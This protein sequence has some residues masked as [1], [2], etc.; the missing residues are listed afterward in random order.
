MLGLV[1]RLLLFKYGTYQLDLNTFISWSYTLVDHGFSGFYSSAWSDYLPGYL[2]I[3]KVLGHINLS[4][5]FD[6]TLLFKLPAI[7]SDLLTGYLIFLIVNKK[8]RVKWGLAASA[9]YVFNPA[10]ILNSTLWGQVDSITALSI[11]LSLYFL[12]KYP[13]LS[14]FFLAFGT[15]FKPQAAF[16]AP[17]IFT[18]MFKDKWKSSKIL[19]YAVFGLIVFTLGFAPFKGDSALLPFILERLQISFNQYPYGSVNAFNF[20]GLWGF[21]K[22]DNVGILGSRVIGLIISLILAIV[23]LFNFYIKK[24]K[25]LSIYKAASGILLTTFL[26]LTKIHERHLLPVFAPL[27]TSSVTSITGIAIYLGYSV[28]YALNLMY[29]YSY[30]S[31]DHAPTISEFSIKLLILFNLFLFACFL[32][33]TTGKL[34]RLEAYLSG[35]LSS[36]EIDITKAAKKKFDK[37]KLRK[38]FWVLLGFTFVARTLFLWNPSEEYFDE[39]YHAFTARRMY[40]GDP[41]AWQWWNTPP[42]GFAYEWTHPPLA[43]LGMVM[44]MR[45]FGENALGWRFPGAVLGVG[46]VF[47]LYLIVREIFKDELMAI[48]AATVFSLDGLN[49]VLSRIG[50]NDIYFLFFTLGTLYFFLKGKH[51][52]AALMLGLSFASKWS[53]LWVL[54]ILLLAHFVF[55]KKFSASYVWFIVIPPLIYLAS[56]IPMFASGHSW[57]QFVEVQKQ[58]WWYHT[59]LTATHAYSSSWWSWPLNLRPVYLYT[60]S[61]IGGMVGKIYALGNPAVSWFGLV[62]FL[63]SIYYFISTKSRKLLFVLFSYLVFF[64]PWAASPRIMFY[65]HYLPATPFLAI[66]IAVIL[67]MNIKMVLPVIGIFAV[68]FVYFYP[69][70]TGYTIPYWFDL[71]YYWF[72]S[73]R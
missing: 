48:I 58:M 47:L 4:G 61:E 19:L 39:V 18:A 73:W 9:I 62:S 20:W 55:K 64:V 6:Q 35:L 37:H 56:Y 65:Y 8:K 41:K 28:S 53:T 13:Y 25:N 26:F 66:I 43:K 27:I 36:K 59:R 21:W 50:M 29:A 14:S 24:N 1:L 7:L 11:M 52:L 40:H 22:L 3:L 2:Y 23:F 72:T 71:S 34:K 46:V 70:W 30:I 44:G 32:L 60:S 10:V 42:E 68:F 31:T 51:L 63:I 5:L 12:N 33:W 45:V 38:L 54:P 16:I 15:L 69:H 57:G 17:L 67:R 49:L